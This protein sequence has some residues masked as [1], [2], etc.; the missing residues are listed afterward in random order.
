MAE[1]IIIKG[2]IFFKI[3]FNTMHGDTDLYWRV[4]ID[5]QEFLVNSVLCKVD[6]YSEQSFDKNAGA[7]KFHIA[8][9]CSEFKILE[10]KKA[11]FL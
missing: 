11:V 5:E 10:G 6:T 1:E 7:I 2:D 4:L 8:G 9:T 3:R